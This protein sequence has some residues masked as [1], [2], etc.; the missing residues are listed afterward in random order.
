MVKQANLL[1]AFLL[2]LGVLAALAYWGV[3]TGSTIPLKMVL[4]IGTP[5]LALI[6]WATWGAPRSERRLQGRWYWLLRIGF[7]AAGAAALYVAGQHLLG[8]I[9]ALVAVLNCIL[10]YAWK[11]YEMDVRKDIGRRQE[12]KP[13]G[14]I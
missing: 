9:F 5:V 2:E 8:T 13:E 6:V 14:N 11:Q 1:L 10:G 12:K 3:A 4:G 7:D